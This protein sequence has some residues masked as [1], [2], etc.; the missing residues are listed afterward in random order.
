MQT[1]V[2]S[3][4]VH[5]SHCRCFFVEWILRRAY[6]FPGIIE[7]RK[8]KRRF[9]YFAACVG[10]KKK[11]SKLVAEPERA[12]SGALHRFDIEVGAGQDALVRKLLRDRERNSLIRIAQFEETEQRDR[13]GAAVL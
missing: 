11:R 2:M 13:T 7:V 6:F 9:Q 1:G 12:V 3:G 5:N 4:R 10:V 8:M